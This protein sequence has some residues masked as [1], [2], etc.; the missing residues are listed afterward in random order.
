MGAE[1]ETSM[2]TASGSRAVGAVRTPRWRGLVLGLVLAAFLPA[3]AA[4]Q[5]CSGGRVASA[6][7]Q[8]RCCW[9]G[10]EWS[11]ARGRCSG[12]PL[13]PVGLVPAGDECV[14][15]AGAGAPSSPPRVVRRPTWGVAIP[16]IVALALGWLA[17][18]AVT[19]ALGGY[20]HDIGLMSIPLAGPWVCLGACIG[21]VG[22]YSPAIIADGVL[23]LT[24]ATLMVVGLALQEEVR[25]G[26]AG[27]SLRFQPWLSFVGESPAAGVVLGA[28]L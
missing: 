12:P 5:D 3:A 14:A 6:A 7:T 2:A 1:S 11:D 8:G 20:A 21:N 4:A 18:P 25:L 22:P 27:A 28:S 9:P 24:G 17:A 16:G 19:A 13:C 15:E 23:Q 10:Q 26:P